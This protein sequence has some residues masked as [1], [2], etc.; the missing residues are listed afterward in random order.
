MSLTERIRTA[1]RRF[2]LATQ[3][4][5]GILCGVCAYVFHELVDLIRRLTLAPALRQEGLLRA[6]AVIAVPAAAALLIAL[7]I[8]RWAPGAGGAN[9]ARVRR[10]YGQ[11]PGLLDGRSVAA[12][13][14]L[15]PVSLGSG[16]PLGPEGP[17]VVVS[18]GLAAAVARL[19]HLPRRVVRGMIPVGTAAGIAAIFNAPITG[20]VFALEE[21]LGTAEKGVLGGAIVASVAAAVVERFLLGGRPLLAAQTPAWSHAAEL[22]VFAAVG[23][24]AGAI[25]GLAMRMIA[26]LR[27]VLG[28]AL[29]SPLWRASL[30]GACVG[31]LALVS[32]AILGVGYDAVTSWLHGGGSLPEVGTALAAKTAALILALSGGLIGGTFAPSLFLGAALG[33]SVRQTAKLLL[34]GLPLEPG[35]YALVGMGAFFAGMLRCPIAAVLIVVEV[36]GDYALVLPLMLAVSLAIAI[37][38]RISPANIVERQL[39]EEGF[40]GERKLDP[41]S[42]LRVAD[43]M[44]T[45]AVVVR[46]DMTVLEAARFL[47]GHRHHFYPAVDAEGNLAGIVEAEA[48]DD[49]A[50]RGAADSPIAELVHPP[51]VLAAA[52]MPVNDLVRRM[53]ARGLIRCPVVEREGS[54]RLVG[55]VSPSDLLRARIRSLDDMADEKER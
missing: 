55:F 8:R 29:P 26:A 27:P 33:S 21:V 30:A 19:L 7:L 35:A 1:S 46:S 34:P 20:V 43:V 11:D 54:R 12:T 49:A 53:G 28:R 15:T 22:L 52:E 31:A 41:L 25:S 42:D 32:P 9:L 37:S 23:V 40:R 45:D 51:E 10:A 24:L 5:I 50:R 38:R 18:S 4:G 48:I 16:A 3:I 44:T 17:I 39:A 2:L 13:F 14:L 47:A 36:T 6:A